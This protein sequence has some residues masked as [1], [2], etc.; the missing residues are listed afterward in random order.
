MKHG[1]FAMDVPI[2]LNVLN[3]NFSSGKKFLFKFICG[4]PCDPKRRDHFIQPINF[5]IE[6]RETKKNTQGQ[7]N[8]ND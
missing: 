3:R 5:P 8:D 6:I 7:Q 2:R 4:I 1:S